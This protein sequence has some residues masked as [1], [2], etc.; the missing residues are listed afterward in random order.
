MQSLILLFPLLSFITI[1]LFGRRIGDFA[2]GVINATAGILSF[3]VALISMLSMKEPEDIV[4]YKFLPLSNTS[5]DIGIYIDKLSITTTVTVTFVASVIFV[6]A[7]GYM[8]YLFGKWTFKFF[9]YFSLFLF[10]MLLILL[11][12]SLILMFFGWEGVGL[13]SYLLIGYFHEEKFAT[14]ASLEAFVMNRIGDW[15]FILGII[16]TFWLFG[17][18]SLPKLFENANYVPGITLATLLLFGGAVGKS[19]Q[20]PL[21]TWLPNAMAGPTPVSALLHAATMV[22]AGVYMV[23]RLYP[24]FSL[25]QTTLSYIAIT[26]VVTMLFAALVATVHDDIKKIIAFSTMSQLA[27]MFTALGM[28][29]P[30]AA[31]FHLTTH[32]FFKALLF[33][34][35]GAVITGLHH[36]T[37]NIFEM[38]GLKKYMPITFS[39]FMIGAL[40]LSGFPPFAGYF[41]KDAI[42]SLIMDK[43]TLV[44]TLILVTSML[45]AYYITREAFVV[46]LGEGHYHEEPHEV[47]PIMSF[48]MLILSFLSLMGGFLLWNY[49]SYMNSSIEPPSSLMAH[50]IYGIIV[51]I[52]GISFSY[53]LYVKKIVDPNTLYELFKP[54][55]TLVKSQFYTEYI[56]HNIIAKGYL[57]ISRLIYKAVDRIIIDGFVNGVAKVFMILVRFVWEFIDIRFIDIILHKIVMWTFSFGRKLKIIQSGYLNQY[58]FVIL[59]GIVIILG[60]II[61]GMRL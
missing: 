25:S 27:I 43:N 33:L 7:I 40:A 1:S 8:R 22:A 15:S 5:V 17:T 60:L 48:P 38:G 53:L 58:I 23:A 57:A 19:G 61:K 28:G 54:I 12:D 10:S 50:S 46:F 37:Q 34:A 13:A 56:Y 45:T 36:H 42:V 24:I 6:Y 47:E 31:M 39:A 59:L 49:F 9:A 29:F 30:T 41:S 11:G 21:H 18:L 16:Y 35:A 3:I 32:A 26:G 20:L 4:F 51:A 52:L 14:K 44:A 2:S 55:H